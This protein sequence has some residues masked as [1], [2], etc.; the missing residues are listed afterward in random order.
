MSSQNKRDSPLLKRRKVLTL[1]QSLEEGT[2]CT[3]TA[4]QCATFVMA[5]RTE[6]LGAR[7]LKVS[8]IRDAGTPKD[9]SPALISASKLPLARILQR[10]STSSK[11]LSALKN[12]YIIYIIIFLFFF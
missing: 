10:A 2:V 12:K 5:L 9:F 3:S 6:R 7:R 8:K 4:F 1:L 11:N